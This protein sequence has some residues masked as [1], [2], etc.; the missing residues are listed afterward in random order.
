ML[1]IRRILL[2]ELREVLELKSDVVR[3]VKDVA[4]VG[5]SRL[6]QMMGRVN[7]VVRV[8]SLPAELLSVN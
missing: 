4:N 6:L 1:E 3:L 7:L 2:R 8:S 5:K